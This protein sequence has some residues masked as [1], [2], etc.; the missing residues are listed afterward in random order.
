LIESSPRMRS[1][2]RN[3]LV[4]PIVRLVDRKSLMEG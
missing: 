3:V 2:V 1:V 4:R